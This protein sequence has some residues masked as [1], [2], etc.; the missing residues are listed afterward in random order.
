MKLKV[1]LFAGIAEAVGANQI[2]INL[3]SPA[4]CHSLRQQI[5]TEFPQTASLLSVSRIAINGQ[6]ANETE[7]LTERD[8][9]A[10]LPPVS[11]G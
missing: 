8:A 7:F 10:I 5:E 11:G 6:Y 1:E 3:E 9:I 2:E 4:S